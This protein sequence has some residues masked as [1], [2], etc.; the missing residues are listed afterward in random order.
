MEP[1][2]YLLMYSPCSRALHVTHLKHQTCHCE[3]SAINAWPSMISFRQ[4]V[5]SLNAER[6]NE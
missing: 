4:P 2:T 3:S 1:A 5:H 6:V